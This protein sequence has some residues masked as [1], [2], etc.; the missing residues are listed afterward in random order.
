MKK[1]IYNIDNLRDDISNY[2]KFYAEDY[3]FLKKFRHSHYNKTGKYDPLSKSVYINN[4]VS[5]SKYDNLATNYIIG[6]IYSVSASNQPLSKT[7]FGLNLKYSVDIFTLLGI[8][9]SV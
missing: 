2:Y 5:V 6:C 7:E 9:V 8:R 1:S 3:S 4:A